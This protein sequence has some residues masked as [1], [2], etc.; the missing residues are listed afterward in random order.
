MNWSVPTSPRS[1]YKIREELLLLAQ[2]EGKTWDD[3]LQAEFGE[4]LAKSE[5]FEGEVPHTP[6]WVGRARFGTMKFWGFVYILI[7][8]SPFSC[9]SIALIYLISY[10]L[11][12]HREH[13]PFVSLPKLFYLISIQYAEHT[14]DYKD[15]GN[16]ND[17]GYLIRFRA[18]FI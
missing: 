12:E 18:K 16:K 2:F 1:P 11:H 3:K 7:L 13:K 10:R 8:V 5:K 9:K 17:S 4:V 14:I 15:R 6:D